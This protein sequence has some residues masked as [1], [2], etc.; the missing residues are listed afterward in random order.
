MEVVDYT[1]TSIHSEFREAVVGTGPTGRFI[2][3][4]PLAIQLQT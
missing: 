4:R 2:M 3:E 1:R